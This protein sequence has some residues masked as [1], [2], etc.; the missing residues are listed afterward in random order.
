[1]SGWPLPL[2]LELTAGLGYADLDR[3]FERSY[4]YWSLAVSRRV[5]RFTFDLGWFDTSSEASE[6]WGDL[7]DGR[8]VLTLSASVH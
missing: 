1:M 5:S 2:G 6:L 8:L 3:V 4:T 7:A